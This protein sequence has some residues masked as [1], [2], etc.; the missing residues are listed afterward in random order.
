MREPR[1]GEFGTYSPWSRRFSRRIKQWVPGRE[2][3]DEVLGLWQS[4][5]QLVCEVDYS[6]RR[7][8]I[9]DS[10]QVFDESE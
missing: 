2:V 6:F 8:P 9:P 4:D 1:S 3:L 7:G 5:V 10:P